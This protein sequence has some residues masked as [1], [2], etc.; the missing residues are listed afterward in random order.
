MGNITLQKYGLG[1]P[2]PIDYSLVLFH[3]NMTLSIG[4]DHEPLKHCI[5]LY[6]LNNCG[7]TTSIFFYSHDCCL[8]FECHTPSLTP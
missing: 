6:V 5:P 7:T 2:K 4:S 1:T 8:V 3:R